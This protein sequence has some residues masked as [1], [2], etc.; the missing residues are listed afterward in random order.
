M[1]APTAS[2]FC[3]DVRSIKITTMYRLTV[4]MI[5]GVLFASNLLA[6][7]EKEEYIVQYING[8]YRKA[9]V[10]G[11]D[12]I[13]V[14][15]LDSVS[16]TEKRNYNN[17]DERRRYKQLRYNALKVYGYAA[18]AVQVYRDT[19]EETTDMRKR[20]AKKYTKE[21][22]EELFNTYESKIKK[23]TKVQ[24]YIL[25]KM[26]ERELDKPFYDVIKEMRGGWA[27]FKWQALANW[28]GFNLKRGYH[29]NDDPMLDMILEDL[30]ISYEK[31]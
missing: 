12:T 22:Q 8:H 25:I 29:P 7:T 5:C 27:A 21:R 11:K 4:L 15:E 3:V 19:K 10:L 28:W 17:P 16:Y 2:Y 26:I 30:N 14:V 13:P 24:G 18:D 23:L 9:I 6:Q 1:R 31:N 20:K